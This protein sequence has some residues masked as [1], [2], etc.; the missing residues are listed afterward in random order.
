MT[1]FDNKGNDVTAATSDITFDTVSRI[2]TIEPRQPLYP[3]VQRVEVTAGLA[4]LFSS[5][6]ASFEI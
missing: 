1:I 4:N 2:F 3:I 5:A 6:T